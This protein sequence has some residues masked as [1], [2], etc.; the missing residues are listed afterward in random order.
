[1]QNNG[2][3]YYVCGPF[4]G[5]LLKA[6]TRLFGLCVSVVTRAGPLFCIYARERPKFQIIIGQ[7]HSK[8]H[9]RS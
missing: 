2:L 6:K 7:L 8:R 3:L 5:P 1:M 4:A 9:T